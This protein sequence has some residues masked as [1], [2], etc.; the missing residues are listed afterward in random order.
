MGSMNEVPGPSL[1]ALRIISKSSAIYFQDLPRSL[2][3]D[4]R[5]PT[6]RVAAVSVEPKDKG[7]KP[8]QKW[9]LP[10]GTHEKHYSVL[11]YAHNAG[12]TPEMRRAPFDPIAP[13]PW[14]APCR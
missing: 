8:S 3:P 12:A 9:R 10:L 7:H 2:S 11:A 1:M 6:F 5:R 4:F 13:P 14:T